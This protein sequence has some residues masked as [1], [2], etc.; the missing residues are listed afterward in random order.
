MSPTNSN[1][2][3]LTPVASQRLRLRPLLE[4]DLELTRQWRNH[5][6][7][8]SQFFF[9]QVITPE[10]HAQWYKNYLTKTDDFVFV[11]ESKH[12]GAPLGQSALYNVCS[13][14]NRA[15]FGRFMLGETEMRSQGFGKEA[16]RLTCHLGFTQLELKHIALEVK[17]DNHSA[18]ATYEAIGFVQTS[19]N[20]RMLTM[21]LNITT[22]T[23]DAN[24]VSD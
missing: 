18:I 6:D 1:K 12:D 20:D 21:E 24:S 5:P 10:M 8:R 22:W 11:F 16:L 3:S 19:I 23:T 14:S 17:P 7:T 9:D 2:R 4:S 15:E 13:K